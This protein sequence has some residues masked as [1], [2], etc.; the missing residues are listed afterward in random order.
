MKDFDWSRFTKKIAIK[1]TL[2][3]I[4]AAWTQSGAIETLVSQQSS[5]PG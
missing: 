4:Y 1:A 3:D 2:A 5:K